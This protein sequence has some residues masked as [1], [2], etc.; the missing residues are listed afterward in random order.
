MKITHNDLKMAY[1]SHIQRCVPLSRKECPSAE[2]IL[3]ILEK[4]V[5]AKKKGKVIDHIVKC[6]YCLLKFELLLNLI[7]DENEIANEISMLLKEESRWTKSP[8]RRPK[9]L[10][11]VPGLFTQRH[12]PWRLAAV[13]MV[14]LI[15]A[16]LFLISIRPILKPTLDEERGKMRDQVRLLSPTRGQTQ[17]LPLVFRWQKVKGA[18]HYQ[19]EIFD[20]SLRLLWRSSQM[21][22]YSYELPLDVVEKVEENKI[23]FWMITA[24]FPDGMKKES[25]LERFILTKTIPGDH[26]SN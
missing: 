22:D 6:A 25:P 20:G 9:V 21:T 4:P 14:L 11:K 1:K 5:S 17:E 7:R 10:V 12:S 2:A 16:G 13:S 8:W 18:E 24:L 23:Y 3:Q 19:L 26:P 15:I